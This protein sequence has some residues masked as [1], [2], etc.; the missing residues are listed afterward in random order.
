[1]GNSVIVMFAETIIACFQ[2]SAVYQP[3]NGS[4]RDIGE[5]GGL[6]DSKKFFHGLPPGADA[7]LPPALWRK[8]TASLILESSTGSINKTVR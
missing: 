1:M 8:S 7:G 5:I 6:L 3:Q 2:P 4:R